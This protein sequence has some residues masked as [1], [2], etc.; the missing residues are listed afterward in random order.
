MGC[1]DRDP[2]R[3]FLEGLYEG[4]T[5]ASATQRR[6]RLREDNIDK[7]VDTYQFRK[8]EERYSRRVSMEEIETHDYNLNISRYVSTAI[9]EEE[10]DLGAVNRE[11]LA[12][13]EKISTATEIH[14]KFLQEIGLPPLP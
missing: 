7:V 1:P 13:D 2:T 5:L 11:L 4:S 12:L 10:I 8:E 14:N 9:P 3:F 6:N